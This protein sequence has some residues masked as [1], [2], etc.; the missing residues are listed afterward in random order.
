[1]AG[2][3]LSHGL[4]TLD[5]CEAAAF[6]KIGKETLRQLARKGI[7]PGAKIGKRWVFVK[8]DLVTCMRSQYARRWQAVRVTT[9]KE[10]ASCHSTAEVKRGGSVS[11]RPA[12]SEYAALLGL[13]RN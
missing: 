10:V 6:L 12:E 9:V 13:P 4:E 7:V 3:A 1:V 8:A 2:E 5:L 11:R